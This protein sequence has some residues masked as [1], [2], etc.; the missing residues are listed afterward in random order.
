MRWFKNIK[1][2]KKLIIAFVLV[3]L[4]AGVVGTIG[5]LN[6]NKINSNAISMHDYNLASIRSLTKIKENFSDVR[7]DL[8]KVVYQKNANEMDSIKSE[9]NSLFLS[10]NNLINTYEKSLLAQSE[11]T[12][13]W[14]LK[15]KFASYE[16]LS[17]SLIKYVYEGNDAAAES[18]FSKLSTI[19]KKIYSDMDKLIKSNEDQAD[20]AYGQNNLTYKNSLFTTGVIV[21]VSFIIAILL[22]VFIAAIISKQIKEALSFAEA[23]GR[24]D[25]TKSIKETSK[26][27]IGNMLR[28]L[29]NAKDN[30]KKLIIEIVSSTNDIS[31]ASEELSATTE[32]ISAKMD[33]VNEAAGQISDGVQD[34]SATTEEVSASAEEIN[35]TAD[36]ILKEAD[37]AATSVNEI[38]N[39]AVKIKNEAAESIQ[40][41]RAIYDES[42][43]NILKAIENSKVVAEVKTMADSIGSIAGQTNLIAL[44]AAIEAARAGEHGKGFAVVADEVRKLAEES[45]EAVSKIQNMVLQVEEAVKNLSQSGQGVLEFISDNVKPNYEL[46]MNTGVQYEKDA[47]FML[48][49]I[50]KFEASS[51][52]MNEATVQINSAMQNVSA[53]AGE[54]A[55]GTEEIV[56]SVH[57]VTAA[58]T[59]VAK[60]SQSQAELS[61]RLTEMIQK[62]KI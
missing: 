24:G 62:F 51:S 5:L 35:G 28:E 8:L 33:A 59:E 17:N 30:I 31:A 44:N 60:A 3:A 21:A 49:L 25:L 7:A 36:L 34:L 15:S 29:I 58:I 23:L 20:K 40:K 32:E 16:E 45:A 41:S 43:S 10:N 52:Q 55:N 14:D 54:S 6:M 2:S 57:E 42:R 26:D 13:F 9:V 39:R 48:K 11:K 12:Y 53:V 56:G 18:A 50:K 22:G 46:L 1:I 4:L 27:E 61:E 37:S 38:T 47:E 19:R